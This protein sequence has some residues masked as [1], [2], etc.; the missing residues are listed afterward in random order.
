MLEYLSVVMLSSC[1]ASSAAAT[2]I[3]IDAKS[4]I[5]V[6]KI[7]SDI[8]MWK[9]GYE[10]AKTVWDKEEAASIDGEV[11]HLGNTVPEGIKALGEYLL[12]YLKV[13]HPQL[14]ELVTELCGY[15]FY[16]QNTLDNLKKTSGAMGS[17]L[18]RTPF[19]DSLFGMMDILSRYKTARETREALIL[20]E[21]HDLR[22]LDR[23]IRIMSYIPLARREFECAPPVNLTVEWRKTAVTS[24][25]GFRVSS[26]YDFPTWKH[27]GSEIDAE[28]LGRF[29]AMVPVDSLNIN[30]TQEAQQGL[31]FNRLWSTTLRDSGSHD[32]IIGNTVRKLVLRRNKGTEASSQSPQEPI[33]IGPDGCL[34]DIRLAKNL[35]EITLDTIK[36]GGLDQNSIAG[37]SSQLTKLELSNVKLA[38]PLVINGKWTQLLKLKIAETEQVNIKALSGVPNLTDLELKGVMLNQADVNEVFKWL[39]NRGG[40]ERRLTFDNVTFYRTRFDNQAIVGG[41]K[42]QAVE[43]TYI[44]NE[45]SNY[46]LGIAKEVLSNIAAQ[47]IILDLKSLDNVE[48]L[49]Q[50]LED[51]SG[52]NIGTLHEL[53]LNLNGEFPQE[54]FRTLEKRFGESF[55]GFLTNS[56]ITFNVL[57]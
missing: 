14:K 53:Q 27:I 23:L 38:T 15:E 47:K 36:L 19:G 8:G 56:N 6:R 9:E 54:N 48:Q 28:R 32:E 37:L 13:P 55:N 35:T 29:C 1:V 5:D 21:W 49:F 22:R 41:D 33:G 16:T 44:L 52:A 39:K 24:L 3:D 51:I 40:G 30:I 4:H 20:N 17:L 12:C 7:Q 31:P 34:A 42:G 46:N 25:V 10:E 43:V 57:F 45:A 11:I 18:R 26:R 50:I 2:E